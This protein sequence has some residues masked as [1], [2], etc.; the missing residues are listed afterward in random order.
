[1]MSNQPSNTETHN[2]RNSTSHRRLEDCLTFVIWQNNFEH[3]PSVETT[4]RQVAEVIESGADAVL[5]GWFKWG[6]D[7]DYDKMSWAVDTLHENGVFFFGGL[8]CS[9]IIEGEN[10]IPR[11]RFMDLSTCDPSGHRQG[12]YA[13]YATH[14]PRAA[15]YVISCA[16][17]QITAGAD[18]LHL[19]ELWAIGTRVTFVKNIGY[20]N[21]AITEFKRYLARRHPEYSTRDWKCRYDIE[22]L[23][24]F[25]YRRY[26]RDHSTHGESWAND[27][28]STFNENPLARLWKDPRMLQEEIHE[29]WF[30]PDPD[31]SFYDYSTLMWSRAISE[32]IRAGAAGLGRQVALAHNGPWPGMDF[33]N[34]NIPLRPLGSQKPELRDHSERWRLYRRLADKWSGNNHPAVAFIDWPG[35]LEAHLA[36]S[37]EKKET[38]L[39]TAPA[40]CHASGCSY[41]F[42]MR[43]FLEAADARLTGDY[44]TIVRICRWFSAHRFLYAPG[45][46][47]IH[48]QNSCDSV[49]TI[50]W[51]TGGKIFV[52]LI[53]HSVSGDHIQPSNDMTL[54]L[55]PGID[56]TTVEYYSPDGIPRTIPL[57]EHNLIFHVTVEFHAVLSLTFTP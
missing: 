8:T 20:D 50:G 28:D 51:L 21:Y 30:E 52:H 7:L 11:E 46:T 3:P 2:D 12:P 24:S 22:D 38:Y 39:R 41:A 40:E 44:D 13:Y 49:R 54:T 5:R 23:G 17:K 47:E 10:G 29:T 31:N 56:I 45:G 57:P 36:W 18:G 43:N 37:H 35:D 15:D 19:D 14:N 48:V 34:W 53:N 32:G 6:D 9:V 16:M 25:D 55:P 42:H 33:Q 4:R 26:L 1:M 27:P